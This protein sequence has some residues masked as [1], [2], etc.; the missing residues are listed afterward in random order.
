MAEESKEKQKKGQN[1][2]IMTLLAAL[3]YPGEAPEGA[4]E[5]TMRVDGIGE[6]AA[7]FLH[8]QSDVH[9]RLNLQSMQTA[10]GAVRLTTPQESGKDTGTYIK[11][12][13]PPKSRAPVFIWFYLIDPSTLEY[14]LGSM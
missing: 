14:A 10:K 2:C 4:V 3:E 1:T 11:T 5:Y 12:G 13:A 6:Q 8:M 7:Y 9:R